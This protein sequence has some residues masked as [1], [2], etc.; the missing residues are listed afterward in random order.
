MSVVDEFSDPTF[1]LEDFPTFILPGK[2]LALKGTWSRLPAVYWLRFLFFNELGNSLI[3]L[4]LST[5]PWEHCS[6][7]LPEATPTTMD[8][9]ICIL[10]SL[11]HFFNQ[12]SG[13]KRDDSRRM[14]ADQAIENFTQW[15]QQAQD[16]L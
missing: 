7:I 3:K 16:G 2:S 13:L 1:H 15:R 10:D 12:V 5:P 6:G 14:M 4:L 9:P 8:L 11:T